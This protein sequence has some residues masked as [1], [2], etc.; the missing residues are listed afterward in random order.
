MVTRGRSGRQRAM[1]GAMR[2]RVVALLLAVTGSGCGSVRPTRPPEALRCDLKSFEVEDIYGRWFRAR[3]IAPPRAFHVLA[4]S[5]GGEFGAYGAGFLKGW[6]SVGAAAV[7]SARSNIQVVT[8]VSTGAIM[9]THAFLGDDDR[10]LYLY[11]HLSGAKIYFAGRTSEILTDQS[12]RASVQWMDVLAR[13]GPEQD[14]PRFETSY[15]S[16]AAAACACAAEQA[17]CAGGGG[18]GGGDMFCQ[19]F[20]ECLAEHGQ[21]D[22][23]AYASGAHPWLRIGDVFPARRAVCPEPAH[24]RLGQ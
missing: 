19:P 9:A 22:G 17:S 1:G 20:M 16:A 3:P 10:L 2:M 6:G 11:T 8:G 14:L 4:L 13:G 7:P 12:L 24:R 15:A 23:Q 21:A 5:A 18:L